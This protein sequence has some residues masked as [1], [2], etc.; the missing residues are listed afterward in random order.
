M[1]TEGILGSD[2]VDD[3]DTLLLPS[4]TA[5]RIDVVT[6]LDRVELVEVFD[7]ILRLAPFCMPTNNGEREVES[8]S[9]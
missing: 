2:G 8:R 1:I 9:D 4:F 7:C 5:D 3:I 6:A